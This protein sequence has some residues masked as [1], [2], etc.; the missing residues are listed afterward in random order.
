[1]KTLLLFIIVVFTACHAN[2]YRP[3]TVFT[4]YGKGWDRS[5]THIQC[6]SVKLFNKSH[7]CIYVDGVPTDIYAEEILISNN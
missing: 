7:A 5:S 1:M 6:D 2:K 4:S 3:Y